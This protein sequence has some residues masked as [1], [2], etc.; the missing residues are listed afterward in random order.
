MFRTPPGNIVAHPYSD[1]MK[2]IALSAVALFAIVQLAGGN[3]VF[4]WKTIEFT[5]L[6]RPANSMVDGSAYYDKETVILT[7]FDYDVETGYICGAFPRFK[8]VP[9]TIGCFSVDD[10]ST[11]T[12]KFT[13]F[14]TAADNDLPVSVSTFKCENN[15]DLVL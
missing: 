9:V 2:A 11:T 6:I 1:K 14:P 13:P 8:S 10:R 3:E 5:D 4:K 7:G 15:V 12:P